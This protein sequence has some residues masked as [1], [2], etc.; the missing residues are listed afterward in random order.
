MK[1]VSALEGLM[2]TSINPLILKSSSWNCR[3]EMLQLWQYLENYE[4]FYQ[5]NKGDL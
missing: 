2:E 4:W 5:K 1:V 3:L